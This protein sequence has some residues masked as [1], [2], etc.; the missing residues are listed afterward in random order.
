MI[1]KI[2]GY[3]DSYTLYKISLYKSQFYINALSFLIINK[4]IFSYLW[5]TYRIKTSYNKDYAK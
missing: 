2:I 4:P 5:F 1:K 3:I